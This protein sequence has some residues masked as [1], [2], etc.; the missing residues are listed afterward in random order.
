[1][2]LRIEGKNFL[3]FLYEI[4]IYLLIFFTYE[5]LLHLAIRIPH[6]SQDVADVF[7]D[8][9]INDPRSSLRLHVRDLE[10]FDI[11]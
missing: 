5:K 9:A 1:M 4:L 7:L 2:L 11:N 3:A 10:N 6:L 8:C